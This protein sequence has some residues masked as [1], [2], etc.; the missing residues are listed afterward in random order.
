MRVRLRGWLHSLTF[1]PWGA[2]A[3]E[4]SRVRRTTVDIAQLRRLLA[5]EPDS[6]HSLRALLHEIDGP[7]RLE[8]LSDAELAERLVELVER[9]R[10]IVEAEPYVPMSSE[11]LEYAEVEHAIEPPTRIIEDDTHWVEVELVDESGEPVAGERCRITL[12]DG[13][14]QLERT[15]ADG[16]IRIDRTIAG[17]CT[18]CFIDLDAGAAGPLTTVS[19]RGSGDAPAVGER[20][21]HHWLEIELIG[22]DGVG[23][24]GELCE[25]ILPNGQLIRRTTD[26]DGL[27][28]LARLSDE[29]DCRVSFPNIDAEAWDTVE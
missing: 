22:E 26:A 10:L 4:R 18:F 9:G 1:A 17:S 11:A 28:R 14:V 6:A 8:W 2:A 5:D 7:T 3:T 29:G 19:R 23:I 15:N 20:P 24:A 25:I 16:L 27:V 21:S 13:R 12:P